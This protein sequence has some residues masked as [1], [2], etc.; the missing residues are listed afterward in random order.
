[1]EGGI[2]I[3]VTKR[4]ASLRLHRTYIIESWKQSR[5]RKFG[6]AKAANMSMD[7]V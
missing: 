5:E 3:G 7:Y 4:V 1:M 2:K 6:T